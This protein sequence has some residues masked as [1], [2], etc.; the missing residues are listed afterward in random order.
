MRGKLKK[1]KR[2]FFVRRLP[3]FLSLFHP[4]SLSSSFFVPSRLHA[5]R[6][7]PAGP[8][9]RVVEVL[10]LEDLRSG[11]ALEDQLRDAVAGL[12]CFFFRLIRFFFFR[13]DFFFFAVRG[14]RGDARLQDREKKNEKPFFPPPP[15]LFS[16]WKSSP[17]WLNSTTPTS[18]R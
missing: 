16:P 13:L 6:A 15:F 3:L 5:R 17:E 4:L 10:D 11:D 18:P 7:I 1:K 12:D 14:T 2:V 9:R 8:A